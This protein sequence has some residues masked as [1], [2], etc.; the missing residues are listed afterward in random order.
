MILAVKPDPGP[1]NAP[2]AVPAPTSSSRS[3]RV[4]TAPL[5]AGDA[6]PEEELVTSNGSPPDLIGPRLHELG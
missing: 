6:V 4:V 1:V 2:L 5:V 3:D